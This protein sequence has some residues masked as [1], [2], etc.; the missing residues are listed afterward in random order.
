MSV[1]HLLLCNKL[2]QN[3]AAR[4]NGH[5]LS[6]MFLRVSDL[7]MTELSGSD[8]SLSHDVAVKLSAGAAVSEQA[9]VSASKL[10]HAAVG[11]RLSV[12]HRMLLSLGLLRIWFTPVRVV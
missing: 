1:N 5:L 2:P 3:I 9:G 8:F 11:R 10:I 7:G 12:S 4:N 6:L